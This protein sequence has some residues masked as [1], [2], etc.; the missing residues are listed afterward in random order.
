MHIQSKSPSTSTGDFCHSMFYFLSC[1]IGVNGIWCGGFYKPTG[2][3]RTNLIFIR[4]APVPPL[5]Y[6]KLRSKLSA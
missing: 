2:N 5:L 4:V 6:M 3:L 1:S